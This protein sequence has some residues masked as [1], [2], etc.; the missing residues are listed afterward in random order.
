[1]QT[2]E[3]TTKCNICS[4]RVKDS[5]GGKIEGWER[6]YV[7]GANMGPVIN[8][9]VCPLNTQDHVNIRSLLARGEW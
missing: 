4:I 7:T 3:Y 6:F 9:D 5:S 1:M 8:I 2:V